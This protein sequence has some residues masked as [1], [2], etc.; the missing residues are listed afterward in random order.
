[1]LR[2]ILSRTALALGL[3]TLAMPAV[4]FP[5]YALQPCK[6]KA[7][8]QPAT[9]AAYGKAVLKW[10][11]TSCSHSQI[12]KALNAKGI[13]YSAIIGFTLLPDGAVHEVVIKKS[14]GPADADLIVKQGLRNSPNGPA[15]AS[16]MTGNSRSFTLDLTSKGR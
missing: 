3:A 6:T 7:I 11:H 1:M 10:L 8:K 13:K 16:E 5:A 2:T 12:V 9:K 14:S 15:F 4:T